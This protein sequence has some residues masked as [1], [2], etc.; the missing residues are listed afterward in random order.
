MKSSLERLYRRLLYFR[1]ELISYYCY[2]FK[3]QV[4]QQ[5]R[6]VLFAQG[7]TGSTLLEDLICSTG[8]F[9]KNGELLNVNKGEI[10]FPLPFIKGIS[11][12]ES[13]KNFIFH[14]KIYQLN[15]D[16]RRPVDAAEFM[17]E[18][19][20]QG[21]KVIYL[22]RRNKVKHALSNF[23]AK[24]RSSFHKTDDTKEDLEIHI[25]PESFVKVVN[26]RDKF[27]EAE[28]EI[29]KDKHHLE[30]VYE[31][32]LKKSENHQATVDKIMD[33]LG[34]E[35]REVQTDYKKVIK[36]PPEYLVVNYDELV[37][38]IKGNGWS[39]YLE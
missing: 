15:R 33:Y 20:A 10:L 17:A 28:R 3:E 27:V 21:W 16:R 32:D 39:N 38:R 12:R 35:R 24:E 13:G 2:K 7:R 37:E 9:K 1:R 4:P 30:I 29:L 5:V 14:V 22:H 19:Y 26:D 36:A 11:K 23:I 34:L 18:L 25:D 8:H 6:V 31:E